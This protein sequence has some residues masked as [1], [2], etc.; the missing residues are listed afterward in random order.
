VTTK[1]A[2]A[3]QGAATARRAFEASLEPLGLG[4]GDAGLRP[5]GLGSPGK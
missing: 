4:P 1:L 2:N 3:D 5:Y